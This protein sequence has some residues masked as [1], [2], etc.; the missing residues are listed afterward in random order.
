MVNEMVTCIEK[1]KK[2]FQINEESG[3]QERTNSM[4][5][6]RWEEDGTGRSGLVLSKKRTEE[7]ERGKTDSSEVIHPVLILYNCSNKF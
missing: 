2:G 5:Q 3:K 4:D 6:N 7:R 1:G